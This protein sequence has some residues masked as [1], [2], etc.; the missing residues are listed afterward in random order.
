MGLFHFFPKGLKVF[1]P[2]PSG[3]GAN[4]RLVAD[5]FFP[6]E[7][8][9]FISGGG[10]QPGGGSLGLGLGGFPGSNGTN[11]PGFSTGFLRG[12]FREF[13]PQGGR[14]R[15][16]V[17]FPWGGV[18]LAGLRGFPGAP[19]SGAKRFSGPGSLNNPGKVKKPR[20]GINGRALP[21][22]GQARVE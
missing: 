7:N 17:H 20:R 2:S 19:G 16:G 21:L 18:R 8:Q 6:R 1:S 14:F 22:V 15:S 12:G 4:F 11:F 5:P 13:W 3:S 9:K 10:F